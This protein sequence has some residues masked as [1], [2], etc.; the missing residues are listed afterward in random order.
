MGE[1]EQHGFRLIFPVMRQGQMKNALRVTPLGQ[2]AITRIPRTRL[3]TRSRL[4]SLPTQDV[5]LNAPLHEPGANLNR[6]HCGIMPQ[7]MI[8]RQG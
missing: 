3:D 2:E 8:D 4:L 5:M 1:A 6:F 7:T